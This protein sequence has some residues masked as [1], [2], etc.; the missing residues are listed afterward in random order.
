M[1]H[2]EKK[3]SS[4]SIYKGRVVSLRVDEVE[5]S[6][7][8]VATREV[9]GHPGAV[10]IVALN[11]AKEVILVRQYRYAVGREL[12][13]IPAGKLEYGEEPLACAIRELE[14]ET[15]FRATNLQHLCTY[16]TTPGFSDEIM[17]LYLATGLNAG[18]ASPQSD[19]NIVVQRLTLR[20]ALHAIETGEIVDAKTIIGLLAVRGR[21]AVND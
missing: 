3:L 8:G 1:S 15:G 2:G 11:E 4:R 13:E 5:L 16:F 14:E 9:V 17:Y 6:G 18:T 21:C 7:G 20:Q 12:L 19:E 10:S